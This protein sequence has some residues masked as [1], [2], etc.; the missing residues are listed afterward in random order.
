MAIFKFVYRMCF[1]FLPII[2]YAVILYSRTITIPT[3]DDV[4]GLFVYVLIFLLII[5]V[6]IYFMHKLMGKRIIF[7]P[8]IIG[9]CVLSDG[10]KTN[11]NIEGAFIFYWI[12]LPLLA[13]TSIY[14]IGFIINDMFISKKRV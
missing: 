1:V 2:I 9:I 7:V 3:E 10:L 4:I 14:S 13:I 6:V 5:F 11:L 12:Q 8:L